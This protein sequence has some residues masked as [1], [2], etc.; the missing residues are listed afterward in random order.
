MKTNSLP[1][2]FQDLE[3]FI[4]WSLCT[5]AERTQK[6]QTTDMGEARAFYEA[7]VPRMDEIIDYLNTLPIDK[8][9]ADAVRLMNLTFS[10]AEIAPAVELFGKAREDNTFDPFR[11]VPQHK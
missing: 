11:Y 8:L 6:R 1:E 4:D 10:L 9:P 5:E 2:L 7:V 3:A